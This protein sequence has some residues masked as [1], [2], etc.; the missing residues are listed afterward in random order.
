MAHFSVALSTAGKLNLAAW[1]YHLA[2][3]DREIFFA[4]RHDMSGR[5]CLIF[6]FLLSACGRNPDDKH[7]TT[8]HVGNG[9]EPPTL[10]PHL[11]CEFAGIFVLRGLFEGLVTLD[12]QTLEVRGGMATSWDT[13]PDG[14][15]YCFELRPDARWSDGT[16][17][18]AEH[19]VAGVRRILNPA[20][21]SPCADLI[22]PVKNARAFYRG[23]V[24]WEE[25]GIRSIDNQ[26]LEIVLE[27]PTPYFLSLLVH[28]AW[29]PVLP[30][31][32][33]KFNAMDH[34]DTPWA[35]PGNLCGNGAY[36]LRQWRVGDCIVIE[37][38][39]Y[40]YRANSA[41][42]DRVI[43]YP[44][45]KDT[46]LT[47]FQS[48]Q[49]DVS[50]SVP[51]D[52]IE[53]CRAK[54]PEWLQ[55]ITGLR[56]FYYI[57]NC[58]HQPLDDVRVRR[59]LALA[60]DR[61][62][63]CQ[64]IHCAPHS[65]AGNLVPPGTGGYSFMGDSVTYDP[66]KA[67]E[68]LAEAGYENGKNFPPVTLT[69]N[70]SPVGRLIAQAAQEMWRRELGI[71]IALRNEEWKA[72]LL[73]RRAGSYDIG[74][75]GWVGDFNDP[76]TFLELFQSGAT[77]NFTRWENAAYDSLL[78]QATVPMDQRERLSILHEAEEILLKNMPILPLYFEPYRRLVASRVSG[79]TPN[80]LDYHLYQ[81]IHL[82]Q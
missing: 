76:A 22:F 14:T 63:L 16:P 43:F 70:T 2:S 9:A 68:L 64:L 1:S 80:L 23:K 52:F 24:P 51:M 15:I 29:A 17:V 75:G 28:P 82:T 46:E 58:K 33:Q 32:L 53:T 38:N 39:P 73:T 61:G 35:R 44:L 40:Y 49:I 55:E 31:N 60:I 4:F 48:G 36:V 56:S 81:N 65:A 59:A 42:V 13:S 25:V 77:N 3:L 30:E 79:W 6:L 12:D 5:V 67:R 7:G 10:D 66:E 34:R 20:L 11:T 69:F 71:E 50:S 41:S 8:L 21:A 45:E 19:F 72:F 47:A 57:L 78:A 54:H 18:I 26:H 62:I 74:R 37:K 27:R